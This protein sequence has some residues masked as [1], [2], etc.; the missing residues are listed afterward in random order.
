MA[1]IRDFARTRAQLIDVASRHL[2]N[3]GYD[4]TPVEA[5][6][7]Q[8]EVSKG[9]FYHHFSSKEQLL[10]AVTAFIV[11]D[12][13]REIRNAVGDRSVGATARLNRFLDASRVWR[14]AHFGL[15]RE[16][17]AVLLRDENAPM[18]RKIQALS[19][20]VCV[21]L[22]A[23]II[24]Q[25]IDEGVFDPPNPVETARLILQLAMSTQDAQLRNLLEDISEA[26]LV[27]LQQRADL[28]V[29]MLERMLGAPT[30]SVQRLHFLEALRPMV[31]SGAGTDAMTKAGME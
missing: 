1:R 20:S 17:V 11:D 3:H 5:I 21:P 6:I 22:L 30:G 7:K 4:R 16:V 8:A 9:A 28:F 31:V 27:V 13:L 24:Q 15:W 10:D 12:A 23:E 29:E 25:G 26:T 19:A 18:L 14:L 2:A